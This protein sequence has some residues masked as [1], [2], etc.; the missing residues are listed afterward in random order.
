M[1]WSA[2][3][4]QR[5]TCLEVSLVEPCGVCSLR[6]EANSVLG[7]QCGKWIHCCCFWLTSSIAKMWYLMSRECLEIM[8]ADNVGR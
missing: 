4:S 3:V 6:V 1:Y 2:T 5:M 8:A 7:S